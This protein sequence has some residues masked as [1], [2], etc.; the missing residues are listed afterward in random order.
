MIPQINQKKILIVDDDAPQR[1][2]LRMTLEAK[3]FV[4]IEAENGLEASEILNGEFNVR[5]IITD[6][7]MPG[8]DG[9]ELIKKIREVERRYTYII[10]LTT[11]ED[12]TNLTRALQIGADD[13]MVKPVFEDELHLRLASG[14]RLMRME[15]QEALILSMAKMAEYRSHETGLHLERVQLYS[16][17]LAMDICE[18][19]SQ[20]GLTAA[21]AEEI[22]RVSPLHDL[23]KISIPDQILHKPGKLTD[24]EFVC[25]KRHTIFGGN[26]LLDLY[27]QTGDSYLLVAYNVAMYHHEKWDG[28]GYPQGLHGTD[29]PIEGRI[30]ALADVY[31]AVSSK[32]CYKECMDHNFARSLLL[33]GKGKH[34]DP[35]I[36]DS[37]L[38]QED[39]WFTIREK[40][41]DDEEDVKE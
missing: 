34:F 40:Y 27:E 17:T 25:M 3:N 35:M 38:R 32:R 10:V 39:I 29:I 9:F 18:H 33:D 7:S 19:Y 6:L 11:A 24:E 14:E 8:M 28:S 13:Y 22:A 4:V 31:D 36:V 37:F 12:R 30:V 26:L 23:G 2:L 5:Y 20:V 1:L 21:K 16:R 15:S 41:V